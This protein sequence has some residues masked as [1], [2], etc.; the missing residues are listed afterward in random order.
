MSGEG[1]ELTFHSLLQ[2]NVIDGFASVFIAGA[3]FEDSAAYHLW[4]RSG[5]RWEADHAF[6]EKLR[7][8]TH[9][10][11]HLAVI[12]YATERDWSA[13]SSKN[14]TNGIPH[15]TLFRDAADKLL[16]S[17]NRLWQG[18]VWLQD[19]FFTGDRLPNNPLGLNIYSGVDDL[20][21]FSALN[22]TPDHGRFL[23]AHGLTYE[24]AART[25]YC[26]TLF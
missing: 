2:P 5:V 18:N 12:Y 4:G 26:S 10:N 25:N 3:N 7:F 8:S 13:T 23:N 21:F 17:K 1:K 14:T 11:G 19:A 22:P 16:D 15:L 24:Q 6:T 9:Q 20:A